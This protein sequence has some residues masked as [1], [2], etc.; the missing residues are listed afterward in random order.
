MLL[1]LVFQRASAFC[2]LLIKMST[3]ISK[4]WKKKTMENEIN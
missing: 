1:L 2:A 4:I 3:M